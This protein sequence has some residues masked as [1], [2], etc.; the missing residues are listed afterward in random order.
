MDFTFSPRRIYRLFGKNGA[1]KSMLLRSICGLF[2]GGGK[3][4]GKWQNPERQK[5]RFLFGYFPDTGR[6][7]IT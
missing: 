5:T 3:N 6:C 1:G 4:F 2:S 7:A